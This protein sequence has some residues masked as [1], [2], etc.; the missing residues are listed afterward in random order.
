M[1]YEDK[2]VV[3]KTPVGIL[4]DYEPVME[5]S[6]NV[7]LRAL[8]E[9]LNPE[10]RPVTEYLL[11]LSKFIIQ[12][13]D[14][15]QLFLKVNHQENVYHYTVLCPVLIMSKHAHGVWYG[16]PKCC[17]DHF[18]NRH[19]GDSPDTHFD[20][21][22]FI[23][24]PTHNEFSKEEM[25]SLINSNRI[26]NI[27]FRSVRYLGSVPFQG[28]LDEPGSKVEDVHEDEPNDKIGFSGYVLESILEAACTN[29][30][31]SLTRTEGTVSLSHEGTMSLSWDSSH[32][33]IYDYIKH[34]EKA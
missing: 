16:Y 25:E 30:P 4:T 31:I 20:G 15:L 8:G 11:E 7:I 17:I 12:K 32:L 23:P 26:S 5:R 18:L 34:G 13:E 29:G 27:P 2:I 14:Q 22:G 19:G 3:A 10:N 21:S 1:K 33:W 24:C 6:V 28:K 9:A